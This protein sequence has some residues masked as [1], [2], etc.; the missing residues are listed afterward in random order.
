VTYYE[1]GMVGGADLTSLAESANDDA[2]DLVNRLGYERLKAEIAA[3]ARPVEVAAADLDLPVD[4]LDGH[5]AVGTNYRDHADESSVKGGPFL[6]PKMVTPTSARAPIPAR[7]ALLDYEVELSLVPMQP[8]ADGDH[9]TGGLILC[10]DVTDRALLLRHID[11]GNPQ[12]GR[13]FTTG[14]SA[15]GYLP[16]GNLFIVPRDMEKFLGQLTLQLSVN[17]VE[18][19]RGPVTGWI[20]DFE[21]MLRQSRARR[22]TVWD[23]RGS[24]VRL[25]FGNDGAIPARTLLMAG[26]PAGTVFQGVSPIDYL[27]GIADWLRRAGRRPVVACIVERYIARTRARRIYLQPGDMVTIRVDCMGALANAVEG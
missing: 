4:L 3:A 21:E 1:D 10:N 18:R 8:L 20:W 27:L 13:G 19:Q 5:I 2:I 16:V 7:D 6:F 9:A 24:K 23:H 17:G 14:K 12:S 11:P 26:T 25:P 22:G 15:P